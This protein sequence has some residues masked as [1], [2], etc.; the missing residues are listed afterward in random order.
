VSGEPRRLEISVGLPSRDLCGNGSGRNN[1]FK[2]A[3]LVKEQRGA[4]MLAAYAALAAL[5]AT[6]QRPPFPAGTRV[7]VEALVGQ[8]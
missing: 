3:R 8:G 1:G 6:L 5:P 4:A 2:R 7:L